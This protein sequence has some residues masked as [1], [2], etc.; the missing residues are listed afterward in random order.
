MEF[1]CYKSIHYVFK[2]YDRQQ[3][4]FLNKLSNQ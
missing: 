3:Y 2:M 4:N 1:N